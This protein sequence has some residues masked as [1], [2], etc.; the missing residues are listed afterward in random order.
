MRHLAQTSL[1]AGLFAFAAAP[2]I[3]AGAINYQD[4]IR[5]IFQ[6]SCFNCHNADK[7]KGGLDLTSFRAA[8]AG[9]S[10]GDIVVSQSADASTLLGVMSHTLAPKMPPNGDKVGDDKLK[11]VKQ[12]I[13]QGLRE[14]AS[15]QANKPKKPRVDLSVGKAAVG[16]PDGPPIM[17]EDLPLGPIHHTTKAGAV[18]AVA[19][20]P[21]SPIVASTGQRQ[22]LIHHTDT[23]E[24]LGVLPFAYGQPQTLRFSWTGKLLMVGGGVGGAS[25]TVALY[26]VKT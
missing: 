18:S 9:G 20:H 6:Q 1:C 14:T 21:W 3:A 2:A 24:L 16:R 15:S 12:W 10:S 17:P 13:D 8:M 5:P 26:D 22:V 19:G 4:H 25:G 7:A 23:G 11:L